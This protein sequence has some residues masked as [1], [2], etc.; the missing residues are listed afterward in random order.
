MLSQARLAVL[1]SGFGS[2]LQAIIDAVRSGRLSVQIASVISDNP[3]A[4]A[5]TRARQNNI[6]CVLLNPKEYSTRSA[7]DQAIL[8]EL[9]KY[10]ADWVIL[11]GFMRLLGPQVVAAYRNRILN[12][13]P[14]L[15]P[16]FP[17]THAIKRAWE[18][19]VPVTGVT[20]HFVD[21]GIDTGPIILQ[22][23]VKILDGESLENLEKRIHEVEH[24]LYPKAIQQV[25]D[26]NKIP[27]NK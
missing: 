9:G 19:K 18:A 13:H 8:S 23:E 4:Y 17:G 11:A 12:I 16:S 5:I 22:E 1:C 6:S 7:M 15:L 3:D 2:N 14:A 26:K 27:N 21:E 10:Q 25:I 24:R 20:V